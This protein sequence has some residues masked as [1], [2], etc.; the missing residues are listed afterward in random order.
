MASTITFTGIC[1]FTRTGSPGV[2]TVLLPDCTHPKY[3]YLPVHMAYLKVLRSMVDTGRSDL[4]EDFGDKYSRVAFLSGAVTLVGNF[5]AAQ[6]NSDRLVS[7]A[8]PDMRGLSGSG[9]PIGP[10]AATVQLNTGT[11]RTPVPEN[12]TLL[13]DYGVKGSPAPTTGNALAGELVLDVPVSSTTPAFT[14]KTSRGTL[15]FKDP[16]RAAVEIGCLEVGDI[17]SG[18]SYE[19]RPED[20]DFLFHY[21]LA[22]GVDE[23]RNRIPIGIPENATPTEG[24]RVDCFSAR[25]F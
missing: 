2:V 15:A 7:N 19:A 24:K 10:T 8:V 23:T 17:L 1:D 18:S 9:A 22:G 20:L 6:C 12:P 21:V 13:W 11:F 14:I 16:L 25:W 3:T 5:G 4:A